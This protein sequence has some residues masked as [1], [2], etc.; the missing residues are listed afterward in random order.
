[1]TDPAR[2]WPGGVPSE[3]RFHPTPV[4]GSLRN[5]IKGW[6]LFLKEN[7][8]GRGTGETDSTFEVRQRRKL[9]QRWASMSQ[10]DRDAYQNRAPCRAGDSWYPEVLRSRSSSASYSSDLS[11]NNGQSQ[12]AAAAAA[13]NVRL[14]NLVAPLPLGPR[15]RAL[16]T[17]LRIM[18]YNLDGDDG[19]VFQWQDDDEKIAYCV[20][21][22]AD[23]NL[24]TSA[25]FLK[26]CYIENA[27]FDCMA[28]TRSGTVILH[29][30]R[31]TVVLID[32]EALDTG[33]ILLCRLANNGQVLAEGRV[34]PLSMKVAYAKMTIMG[35]SVDE[36]LDSDTFRNPYRLSSNMEEPLL[37]I[38][39]AKAS[40]INQPDIDLWME[41]IERCAPG[42]LELEDENDGMV[43][44]YDHDNFRT[45]EEL[46]H[47]PWNDEHEEMG[48]VSWNDECDES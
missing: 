15:N 39:D 26:W 32:Q 2:Y 1:M 10:S 45:N 19:T 22:D 18:L 23:P 6:Q 3:V 14:L 41:A 48:H 16:W 47:L 36:V 4:R 20:P 35:W 43:E 46:R 27:N 25:T 44:D 40:Y 9:M 12:S 37:D 13:E 30:R 38:L 21:N 28:M 33:L 7:A 42:Y 8:V 31:S 17:K 34:W 5:E 11:L 29:R 24:L